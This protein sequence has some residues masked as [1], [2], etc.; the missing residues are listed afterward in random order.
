M[1]KPLRFMDKTLILGEK[2]LILVKKK[3]HIKT[4]HFMEK[5]L[6]LWKKKRIL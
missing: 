3:N 1:K 6:T 2:T 5:N 4:P